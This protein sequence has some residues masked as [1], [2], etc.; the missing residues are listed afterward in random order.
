MK[1]TITNAPTYNP[2][3][4]SKV[5]PR[6]RRASV[7]LLTPCLSRPTMSQRRHSMSSINKNVQF[8]AMS[9]VSFI[10]PLSTKH[11]YSGSDHLRFRRERYSDI[12]TFRENL[13][14]RGSGSMSP[15][16]HSTIQLKSPPD[17]SSSASSSCH[18][19]ATCGLP[20][21]PPTMYDTCPVGIEQLLSPKS[22]QEVNAN[23]RTVIHSVLF[24]QTRQK[25]HG[26]YNPDSLAN[27]SERL[28]A[29]AMEGAQKRGKFQEIAKFL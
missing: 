10:E 29:E 26:V 28:S 25:I 4:S 23:R 16:M 6:R 2:N 17:A 9:V 22:S 14:R 15:A 11:W 18:H 13:R 8:S 7:P 5:P 21:P 24:E 3:R 12:R 1:P 19:N 20:P 27:L